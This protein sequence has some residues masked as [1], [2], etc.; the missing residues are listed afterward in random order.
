MEECLDIINDQDEVIGK[1][2]KTEIYRSG[3]HHRIVHIILFNKDGKMLLQKRSKNKHM[4][5]GAWVTSAGGHVT[6][7]E[8][9]EQAAHREL[10]E[11]L[12]V[13]TDLTLRFTD[14]YTYPAGYNKKS[15]KKT[16]KTFVGTHEGPFNIEP[17]EVE[18]VR[19]FSLKKIREISPLHPELQYLMETHYQK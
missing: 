7:G 10:K 17:R 16:L 1:A 14:S 11:E 9:Y 5:A 3:H 19:F 6:S 8:S 4:T 2:P 15:I 13:D 12:G 18:E